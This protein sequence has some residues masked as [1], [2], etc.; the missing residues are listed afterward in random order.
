MRIAKGAVPLVSV[1]M[2]TFQFLTRAAR[3]LVRLA[4]GR[5]PIRTITG[6]DPGRDTQ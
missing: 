5:P 6:C 3:S 1:F 4:A 2:L